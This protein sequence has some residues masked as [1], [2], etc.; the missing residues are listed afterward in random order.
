MPKINEQGMVQTQ[1]VVMDCKIGNQV[2]LQ[3]DLVWG[4]NPAAAINANQSRSN[5]RL[6][7]SAQVSTDRAGK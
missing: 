1:N 3:N 4:A 2:S 7:I 6:K 5:F